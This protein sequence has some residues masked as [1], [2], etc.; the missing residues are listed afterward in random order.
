MKSKPSNIRLTSKMDFDFDEGGVYGAWAVS[1]VSPLAGGIRGRWRIR[2]CDSERNARAENRRSS[3]KRIKA[4]FPA[5][6][7][8]PGL[9]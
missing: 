5:S 2:H 4:R 6:N 3:I 9:S 8:G 1:V 7:A